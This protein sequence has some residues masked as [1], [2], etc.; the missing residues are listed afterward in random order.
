M[1]CAAGAER[2]V[3]TRDGT[4]GERRYDSAASTTPG[5]T[6]SQPRLEA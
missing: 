5:T 3:E 1:S 6:I 2:G 4:D